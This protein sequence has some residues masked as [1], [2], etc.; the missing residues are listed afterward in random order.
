[1]LQPIERS[2]CEDEVDHSMPGGR[3][4]ED[5]LRLGTII[6]KIFCSFT[7]VVGFRNFAR[8]L[9]GSYVVRKIVRVLRKSLQ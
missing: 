1:M 4:I 8:I 6:A 3:V 2:R 9:L 7:M 5:L